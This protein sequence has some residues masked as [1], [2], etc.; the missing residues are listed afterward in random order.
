MCAVQI[1]IDIKDDIDRKHLFCKD[2]KTP[3]INL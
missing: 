2:V 3:Q 1:P